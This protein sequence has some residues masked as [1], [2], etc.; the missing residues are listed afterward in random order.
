LAVAPQFINRIHI[1]P[2]LGSVSVE[3]GMPVVFNRAPGQVSGESIPVSLNSNVR[4]MHR[5]ANSPFVTGPGRFITTRKPRRS[6]N[7]FQ[8]LEENQIFRKG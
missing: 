8:M 5:L 2:F 3:P 6:Q 1:T 4:Q 7:G